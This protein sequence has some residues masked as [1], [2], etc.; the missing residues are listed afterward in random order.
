MI[1][2][3]GYQRE[4]EH[5]WGI[6]TPVACGGQPHYQSQLNYQLSVPLRPNTQVAFRNIYQQ[7]EVYQ[8]V[9]CHRDLFPDDK[10]RNDTF[11]SLPK[12]ERWGAS[13]SHLQNVPFSSLVVHHNGLS[14]VLNLPSI[15][16]K[17]SRILLTGS[18]WQSTLSWLCWTSLST[19]DMTFIWASSKFY[20]C[21]IGLTP[22]T[23]SMTVS[24]GICG[25]AV[26]H[27]YWLA[28]T[29]TPHP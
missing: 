27:N 26:V 29:V 28:E 5:S 12:H 2:G 9:G 7:C 1:N 11:S 14:C 17:S 15:Q 20:S 24:P 18:Q 10:A 22:V 4:L 16:H 6:K 13:G 8:R 25:L 19:T 21:H 3:T 23:Q